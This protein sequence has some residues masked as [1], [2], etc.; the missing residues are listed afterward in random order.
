VANV[1]TYKARPDIQCIQM[2]N[3]LTSVFVSVL[4]LA[5]SEL[6]ETDRQREFAAWFADQQQAISTKFSGRR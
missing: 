5:A 2:N 6:A 4:A 3:G 1:V